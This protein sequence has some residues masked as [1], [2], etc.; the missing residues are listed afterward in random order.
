MCKTTQ[1][2]RGRPGV[3]HEETLAL[4][5]TFPGTTPYIVK[6]TYI[7]SGNRNK[8]INYG[9]LRLV[10]STVLLLNR[11]YDDEHNNS[12]TESQPHYW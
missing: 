2:T 10:G 4:E 5:M 6:L 12:F 8:S 1:L 9:H 11:S 7:E 3:V